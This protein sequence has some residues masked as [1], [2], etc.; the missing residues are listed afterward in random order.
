[1]GF[2]KGF[3]GRVSRNNPRVRRYLSSDHFGRKD[4]WKVS[5]LNSLHL[6]KSTR[7]VESSDSDIEKLVANA[8]LESSEKST[9]H[10]VKVSLESEQ[11]FESSFSFAVFT[12]AP[13][14]SFEY[15]SSFAFAK[16]TTVLQSTP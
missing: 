1:M 3:A 14:L 12:L 7:F 8:V 13:D 16:N 5:T 2:T 10:A 11:S 9:K 6:R 4:N 15:G